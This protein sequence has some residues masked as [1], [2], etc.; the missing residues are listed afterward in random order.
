MMTG[1]CCKVQS[2]PA[3][4]LSALSWGP[5]DKGP[6]TPGENGE[7]LG[8]TEIDAGQSEENGADLLQPWLAPSEW[9]G[10]AEN[11]RADP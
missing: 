2:R 4:A 11:T 6:Q 1:H 8:S 3:K 9:K 5:I 10:L 7:M